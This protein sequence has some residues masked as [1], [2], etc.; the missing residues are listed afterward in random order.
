[1]LIS[2][3]RRRRTSAP[4]S[5]QEARRQ[6]VLQ[7]GP[8]EAIKEGYRDEQ[9][10]PLLDDFLQ[11]VR[12][13]FRQLRRSPLFTLVATISL[14]AG[15]GANA[16]VFTVVERAAAAA[17]AGL[18]AARARLRDRRTDPDPVQSAVLVSRSTRS[19]G[20]TTFS[21]V[22]RR[23][24]RSPLN[25]TVDGQT[26]RSSGELVSGNYFGVLGASTAGGPSAPA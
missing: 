22:S 23:G 9:G 4:A 6:A 26:L 24:S 15:I 12:Y 7:F 10:L 11:D 5:R 13:T 2:R 21:T 20:K 18:E 8:I 1:M 3:W 14:A 16:A 17:A 19:C 25:V